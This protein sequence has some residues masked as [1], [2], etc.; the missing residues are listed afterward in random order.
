MDIKRLLMNLIKKYLK[1]QI[2]N[3]EKTVTVNMEN[4][5]NSKHKVSHI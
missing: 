3:R 5:Q 2:I 4:K 1:I